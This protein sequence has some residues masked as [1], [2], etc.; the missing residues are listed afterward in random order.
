[1]NHDYET[2]LAAGPIREPGP[3]SFLGMVKGFT[4]SVREWARAGFPVASQERFEAR[5]ETCRSCS[6]WRE[7]ERVGLGQCRACR[8]TR[9]KMWLATEKCP[10]G[11]WRS[12][13]LQ[14]PRKDV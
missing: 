12:E 11:K 3:P 4:A 13:G 6:L 10:R 8:C 1:M 2:E 9:L 14:E 5:L 7:E